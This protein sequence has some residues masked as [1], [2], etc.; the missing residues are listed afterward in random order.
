MKRMRRLA[1]LIM[2]TVGFLVPVVAMSS[3]A[4]ARA[5]DSCKLPT[6]RFGVP[7]W[8]K[9][10]EGQRDP[11]NKCRLVMDFEVGKLMSFLSIGLALIEILL[12]IAGIVAIAFIIVGGF[13]YVLSQ[14]NPDETAKAKD[15]IINA[16]IGVAIAIIA[17]GLVRFISTRLV[18]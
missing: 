14:G 3:V 11:A 16:V 18:A 8:Y 13:R 7:T 4:M 6:S 5:G 15:A 9:Y 1:I 2:F 12:F 17:S 10:L